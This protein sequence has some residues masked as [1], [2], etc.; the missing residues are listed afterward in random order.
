[1]LTLRQF[2]KHQNGTY[3]CVKP[4]DATRVK[5]LQYM[6]DNL[7]NIDG[8]ELSADDLHCTIVYSR[9]PVPVLEVLEV[10]FP[11][12]ANFKQFSLFGENNDV[13]VAEIQSEQLTQIFNQ[14][15]DLGA[16]SDWPDYKPHITLAK[17][18]GQ[19]D[20]D[21]LRYIDFDIVFDQYVVEALDLD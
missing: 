4:D 19:I 5:L 7:S 2:L 11:I 10:Q 20:L 13:L 17:N 18:V 14:S 9:E 1:M 21:S 12:I 6:Q 15:S 16:V 3:T 8:I